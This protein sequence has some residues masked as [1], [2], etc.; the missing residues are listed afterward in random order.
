MYYETRKAAVSALRRYTPELRT[1]FK[2]VK[3][4]SESA[5]KFR[6]SHQMTPCITGEVA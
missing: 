4:Y 5:G 3:W 6:W 2:V 1:Q